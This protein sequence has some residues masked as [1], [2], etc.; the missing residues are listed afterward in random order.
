M[1]AFHNIPLA[2]VQSKLL[3]KTVNKEA[4]LN[5]WTSGDNRKKLGMIILAPVPKGNINIQQG[6]T[7][8]FCCQFSFPEKVQT[9][10]IIILFHTWWVWLIPEPCWWEADPENWTQAVAF[11]SKQTYT[12]SCSLY[13]LVFQ[14]THCCLFSKIMRSVSRLS[15]YGVFSIGHD[16]LVERRYLVG[17]AIIDLGQSRASLC[18]EW[19]VFFNL[20]KKVCSH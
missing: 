9:F 6:V 15:R 17:W 11:L 3:A 8:S 14:H 7:S 19:F 5:R 4:R 2:T 10:L 20:Y 1:L 12:M 16:K 18:L 13:Y